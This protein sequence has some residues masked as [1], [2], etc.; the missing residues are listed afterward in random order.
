MNVA[1]DGEGKDTIPNIMKKHKAAGKPW[2]L[3]V[4]Q[5]CKRSFLDASLDHG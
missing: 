5:N 4:D 3:V 1:F 2:M